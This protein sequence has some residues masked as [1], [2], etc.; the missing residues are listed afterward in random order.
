MLGA[1]LRGAL[2]QNLARRANF[3][4]QPPLQRGLAGRAQPLGAFSIS[5]PA[6]C[7][8]RAAGVPGRGE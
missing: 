4:R 3:R 8:I 7:G 5:S 2:D 6:T 1:A